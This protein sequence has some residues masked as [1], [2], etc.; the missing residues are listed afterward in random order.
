MTDWVAAGGTAVV[1]YYSGIVDEN[2]RVWAGGY[3]GPLRDALG[4]HVEEF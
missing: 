2:D 4:I 3:T 1:T